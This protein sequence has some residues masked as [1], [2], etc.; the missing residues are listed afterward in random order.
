MTI[1][2]EILFKLFNSVYMIYNIS[3][4]HL[5]LRR[6]LRKKLRMRWFFDVSDVKESSFFKPDLTDPPSDFWRA[7]FGILGISNLSWINLRQM[8]HRVGALSNQHA[9][10]P[11]FIKLAMSVHC[12]AIFC[13]TGA[14]GAKPIGR[15]RVNIIVEIR[16][17]TKLWI[18]SSSW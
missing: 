12:S 14:G 3:I 9:R 5:T 17:F 11:Y 10:K 18:K 16:P 4:G 8:S 2:F 15:V 1:N 7:S 6:P 13:A